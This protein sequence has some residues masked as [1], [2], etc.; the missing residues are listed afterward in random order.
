MLTVEFCWTILVWPRQGMI[1]HD[2]YYFVPW[3][4]EAVYCFEIIMFFKFNCGQIFYCSFWCIKEYRDWF[5]G[6]LSL[7]LPVHQ[8]FSNLMLIVNFSLFLCLVQLIW[9]RAL[10]LPLERPKSVT[11][12]SLENYCKKAASSWELE[13][14]II[15]SVIIALM[16]SWLCEGY[17]ARCKISRSAV[18]SCYRKTSTL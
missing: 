4:S 10:G 5:S 7:S 6:S 11:M 8:P 16:N 17:T 1:F 18:F 15:L 12:E 14:C 2:I 13:G 3:Y 9:D